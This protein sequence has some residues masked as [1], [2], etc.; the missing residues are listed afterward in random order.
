MEH[1]EESVNNRDGPPLRRL[2]SVIPISDHL[3]SPSAGPNRAA[4][5]THAPCQYLALPGMI[6]RMPPRGS[7]TSPR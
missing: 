6:Q 7:S 5:V 3:A 1:L 2:A 4:F